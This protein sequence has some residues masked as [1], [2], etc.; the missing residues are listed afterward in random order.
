MQRSTTVAR[1]IDTRTQILIL[2]LGARCSR[3]LSGAE[4]QMTSGCS[5]R[6]TVI[7]DAI[8][9][10]ITIYSR[11]IIGIVALIYKITDRKNVR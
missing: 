7:S 10:E 2:C 5:A 9:S 1:D 4:Q 11:N 6:A 8:A 3:L